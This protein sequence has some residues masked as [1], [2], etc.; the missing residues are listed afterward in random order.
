MRLGRFAR[1]V[2]VHGYLLSD[3]QSMEAEVTAVS[4][5]DQGA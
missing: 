3:G 5:Q 2:Y 1:L 4:S